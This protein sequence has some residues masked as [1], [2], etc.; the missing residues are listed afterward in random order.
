[1]VSIDSPII[2]A[3]RP[4]GDWQIYERDRLLYGQN[5]D[6]WHTVE[7]ACVVMHRNRY[8][9]LYSG[10]NWQSEGYGLGYAVADSALGP[11]REPEAGP[12]V[13]R[14]VGEHVIGPG[15]NSV[16]IGPD[17]ATEFLVY[18]AWNGARTARQMCIDPLVWTPDGPRC[19]GPT[20]DPQTR[21]LADRS[22]DEL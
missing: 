14:G 1:M 2:T 11:Y 15:H 13:L 3:L 5:W 22:M 4:S 6:T 12:V 21:E 20:W 16:V 8:Y 19:A 18:H 10:G 7:G 9:L 17:G